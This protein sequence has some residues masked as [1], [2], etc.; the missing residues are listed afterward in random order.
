[1]RF[2]YYLYIYL[3]NTRGE[4]PIGI[5]V[6]AHRIVVVISST[7]L[8]QYGNEIYGFDFLFSDIQREREREIDSL[9]LMQ[10]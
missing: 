4:A 3:F 10:F 1:V 8:Q 2:I 9:L 5:F 7:C 6:A